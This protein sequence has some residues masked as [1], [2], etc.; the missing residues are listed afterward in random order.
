[1]KN[2][3]CET[4]ANKANTLFV[5]WRW[6]INANKFS[7]IIMELSLKHSSQHLVQP[8]VIGSI[9][10]TVTSKKHFCMPIK[11]YKG[12]PYDVKMN[13]LVQM[14]HTFLRSVVDTCYNLMSFAL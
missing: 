3:I 6:Q 9:K 2:V 12:L 1:M 13:E 4:D 14:S 11:T 10:T 8:V 7:D 5:I